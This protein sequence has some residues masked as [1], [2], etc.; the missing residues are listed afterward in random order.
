[1]GHRTVN[2]RDGTL[3]DVVHICSSIEQLLLS[4]HTGKTP[5]VYIVN[6]L[7]LL[8]QSART[9]IC[10]LRAPA[11]FDASSCS[12]EALDRLVVF[13][14][15]RKCSIYQ[16]FLS[17][18]SD[19]LSRH[20]RRFLEQ[21]CEKLQGENER[22]YIC[23]ARVHPENQGVVIDR[24][25]SKEAYHRLSTFLRTLIEEP[26]RWGMDITSELV[27][28]FLNVP[29][30][31]NASCK[32]PCSI[33][34]RAELR[35]IELF[36]QKQKDSETL[37][38]T[39]HEFLEPIIEWVAFI[40]SQISGTPLVQIAQPTANETVIGFSNIF[41]FVKINDVPDPGD[42]TRNCDSFG[43]RLVCPPEQRR[44]LSLFYHKQR[45]HRCQWYQDK[46]VCRVPGM[47]ECHMLTYWDN[48]HAEEEDENLIDKHFAPAWEQMTRMQ[49]SDVQKSEA[50]FRS[51]SILFDR[52]QRAYDRDRK[53]QRYVVSQAD[54]LMACVTYRMMAAPNGE[55]NSEDH[56]P[57]LMYVP[58]YAGTAPFLLAATVVNAA[59]PQ[60]QGLSLGEWRRSYLFA[61][62]VYQ[63]MSSRLK[64]TARKAYLNKATDLV[65][66]LYNVRHSQLKSP[67]SQWTHSD[68]R[69]LAHV[70]RELD[71]LAKA[72]P[73]QQ[74]VLAK[75]QESVIN[76][77]GLNT[78]ETADRE[79]IRVDLRENP[80]WCLLSHKPL[81]SEADVA[82]KFSSAMARTTAFV[83][84]NMADW[85]AYYTWHLHLF[86]FPP[87]KKMDWKTE[88]KS[89]GWNGSLGEVSAL[90]ADSAEGIDPSNDAY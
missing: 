70:N 9:R 63:L 52:R 12:V 65:Q 45:K 80:Y 22:L 2:P 88:A 26:S 29:A 87:N 6:F 16:K 31:R 10:V 40:Y 84:W 75:T 72:Y 59:S 27:R 42:C 34:E 83:E 73:Y 85:Y 19:R 20:K 57:Q 82:R 46:G 44:E 33:S 21:E 67:K 77:E 24:S 32:L 58:I 30:S 71:N 38:A 90:S 35:S 79:V 49:H 37:N 28:C 68:T 14:T 61:G 81:F 78:F 66:E 76:R 62:M 53:G 48:I 55:G 15:F 41:F 13:S 39:S 4:Y 3:Q 47:G 74:I 89:K 51:S 69:P 1:M 17:Q 60:S 54:K 5:Y 64:E 18:L 25:S 50:A 56:D 11:F 8:F 86:G 23:L 7:E 43:V 36:I